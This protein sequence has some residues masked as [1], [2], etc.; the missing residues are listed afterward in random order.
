MGYI[1]IYSWTTEHTNSEVDNAFFQLIAFHVLGF[2]S[3][4]LLSNAL[5]RIQDKS[6]SPYSL[7]RYHR[8]YYFFE[9]IFSFILPPSFFLHY[10]IQNNV[11]VPRLH[12]LK[13]KWNTFRLPTD[14]NMWK[15]IFLQKNRKIF[16][17]NPLMEQ[18]H[19]QSGFAKLENFFWVPNKSWIYHHQLKR[20]L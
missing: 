7:K 3:Q 9:R 14:Q 15:M 4:H 5:Q 8:S 1:L 19:Q 11:E 6:S 10:T 13:L 12:Q 16:D 17:H 18:Y 2:Y 20:T